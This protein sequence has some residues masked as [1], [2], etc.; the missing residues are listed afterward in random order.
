[1]HEK[2]DKVRQALLT[3]TDSVFHYDAM[4]KSD[5]YIVF[6]E[7]G[8]GDEAWADDL[9]TWQSVTGTID[10]FTRKESDPNVEK[11]QKALNG[12]EIVW[13]LYSVQFEKDTGYIH[14]EWEWEVA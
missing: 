11:I 8:Q 2:I 6:M 1:M 4:E 3:V 14:W 7:D 5:Q 13:S 9:C 12:G 10:Y